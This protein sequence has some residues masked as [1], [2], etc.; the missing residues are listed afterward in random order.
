MINKC[1]DDY[2]NNIAFELEQSHD[3]LFDSFGFPMFGETSYNYHEQ[4][5]YDSYLEYYTRL[6]I[7]KILQKMADEDVEEEIEWPELEL[8]DIYKGYTNA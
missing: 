1:I 3:R 6:M 7:N 4:V 2:I 8:Y 5:Y